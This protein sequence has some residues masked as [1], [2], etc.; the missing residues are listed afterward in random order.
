M[1]KCVRN[2]PINVPT[3]AITTLQLNKQPLPKQPIPDLKNTAERYL[4]SL[5]PLLNESEYN[6]TQKLVYEFI[7]DENIGSKLHKKL[8]KK[9]ESND[10]WVSD[11]WLN[12]AY[13]GYRA[14][15]IVNSS[16]GTIGPHIDFKCSNDLYVFAAQLIKAVLDYNDFI[17]SGKMKQEMSGDVPLDMQP[18]GMILGTHRRP[19]K[20]TD[21]LIH[22]DETN[23]IIII[24]NNHF[25]KLCIV[26]ELGLV[27]E[28]KLVNS[29]KDIVKRSC[30]EAKPVGILTGNDRDIW[31]ED[32]NLLLDLDMECFT[33]NEFGTNEIKKIKL[34]PDSFIQIA[35]QVT[36]YKLHG[37]PPVHYETA[38]LRRFQNARTECI[39]ST[40]IES[41]D[42]AIVMVSNNLS[43]SKEKKKEL[44]IRAIHMHK[45]IANKAI[46][47]EGVDRHLYG[48][49]MIA[50]CDGIDLPKL[51]KDIGYTKSTYF[52]LTSSQVPYKSAS[53]MCYGPVVPEGYGC[54]YNP[55]PTD[56]LIA[57]S[58]FKSCGDTSSKKF[59]NILK[60]VLHNMIKLGSV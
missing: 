51:Y 26:N 58:S 33:F 2:V 44:M 24:S 9:S 19:N 47:G 28:N 52:T 45:Q 38:A 11:W 55:R 1:C 43:I 29:I 10:N 31:V 40:S 14:P 57:C 54:C 49:K 7:E 15:V 39:R 30:V 53:F 20:G 59:A 13:L 60:E 25:F 18:Y 48:L 41:I 34:S 46:I 22:T 3:A 42:F 21:Q 37:K 4:R 27:S 16:P 36:F 5:K 17:K 56:I 8:L 32:Y 6:A 50:M 23:H 35:M 12:T